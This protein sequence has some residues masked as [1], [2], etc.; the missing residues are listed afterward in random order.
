MFERPG[1]WWNRGDDW[2]RPWGGTRA[3][4][5]GFILPRIQGF[6]PAG[7]VLEIAPGFGRWTQFLLDCCDSL[8]GVDLVAQCVEA[9]RARFAE[10]ARAAF[11]QNDGRSLPNVE[12]RWVDFAFTFDSLVHAESDVL[13]DYLTALSAK[14]AI[15]GVAFIHHSNAGEYRNALVRRSKLRKWK[16]RLP[17]PISRRLAALG[18]FDRRHGRGL[19]CTAEGFASLCQS[20]GLSCVRQELVAWGNYRLHVDCISIVTRPGSRWDGPPRLVR[21]EG[22]MRHLRYV[23]SVSELY[24]IRGDE[25]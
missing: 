21:S 3:E 5:Y 8:I 22:F 24:Q 16:N 12:D 1:D 14:L 4:W 15:D 23:R 6:L 9:C 13:A 7:H 11:Y 18:A 10:D 25:G 19:D 2:S 20:V 17:D